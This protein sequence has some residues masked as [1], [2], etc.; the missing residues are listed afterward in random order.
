MKKM[1]LFLAWLC[2]FLIMI[3]VPLMTVVVF[4]QVVM[5]YVFLSP[6][7][8]AEEMA[9]YLLVW[10]SCLGAAYGVKKGQHIGIAILR[11]KFKGYTQLVITVVIHL[12]LIGFFL[13][14]LVKG[15]SLSLAQSKQI[16]PGMQMPMVWAYISVPVAFG[17]MIVFS[18]ELLVEDV[19][20]ILSGRQIEGS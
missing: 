13:V 1:G 8:W 14:C 10:I 18:L 9:R 5:R 2:K 19:K 7:P 15:I 3:M 6:F 12:L 20:K 4:A 16:S 17:F 11:S